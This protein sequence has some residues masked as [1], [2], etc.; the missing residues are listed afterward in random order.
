MSLPP[1]ATARWAVQNG[2]LTR[3]SVTLFHYTPA[4]DATKAVEEDYFHGQCGPGA[5]AI[6][7]RDT[8][9]PAQVDYGYMNTLHRSPAAT[10][11]HEARNV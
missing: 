5:V 2:L 9:G 8:L 10:Y 7:K 6:R 11:T 3:V 1:Y 4:V